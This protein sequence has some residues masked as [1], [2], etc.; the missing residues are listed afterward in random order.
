MGSH[1]GDGDAFYA[2]YLDNLRTDLVMNSKPMIHT[3]TQIAGENKQFAGAV[4]DALREHI[5]EVCSV[6]P[7]QH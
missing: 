4:V 6:L 5:L 3:L 2:A 1:M 7:W